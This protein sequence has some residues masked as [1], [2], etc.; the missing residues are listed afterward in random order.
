MRKVLVKPALTPAHAFQRRVQV[1]SRGGT[2]GF[3]AVS[4][5][6]I[7]SPA[8]LS[9]SWRARLYTTTK[10]ITPERTVA[11]PAYTR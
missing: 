10:T 4:T 5:N 2:N 6:G 8:V 1:N 9:S 11:G 3:S 7:K